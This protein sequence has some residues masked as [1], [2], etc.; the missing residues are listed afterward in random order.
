MDFGQAL[1]ELKN[2]NRVKRKGWNGDGI[3]LA[4]QVPDKNSKM[5][6]PYIYIDTLGLKTNNPNAP[7][8][9]VPWLASQTDMLAEDWEVI[10][11]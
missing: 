1:T 11:A 9:R 6:Q 5:T 10:H 2:G 3:F 8:G 4:L 7:K